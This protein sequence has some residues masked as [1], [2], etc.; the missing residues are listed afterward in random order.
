MLVLVD[1]VK[2]KCGTAALT[3][4]VGLWLPSMR[5]QQ[6]RVLDVVSSLLC[7]QHLSV[8]LDRRWR[9]HP[10]SNPGS[11]GGSSS[12]TTR[13]HTTIKPGPDADGHVRR[14]VVRVTVRG[15]RGIEEPHKGL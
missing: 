1:L 9:R 13:N 11:G 7:L 3:Q 8:V 4:A 14:L 6:G 12:H 10:R 2:I 5:L 15:G